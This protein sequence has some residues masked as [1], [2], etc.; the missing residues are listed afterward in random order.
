MSLLSDNETLVQQGEVI[1]KLPGAL[2][3][4]RIA[5]STMLICHLN[6]RSRQLPSKEIMPEVGSFVLVEPLPHDPSRGRIDLY[7][8]DHLY[9]AE[10]RRLKRLTIKND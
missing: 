4:V 6:W 1:E 7:L 2:Y 3:K 9:R 5:D 8:M 10:K